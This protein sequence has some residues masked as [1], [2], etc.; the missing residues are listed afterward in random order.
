MYLF[1]IHDISQETLTRFMI[2]LLDNNIVNFKMLVNEETNYSN[3][4]D[5]IFFSNYTGIKI[6]YEYLY[7]NYDVI[8]KESSKIIY[9]NLDS[10]V[11]QSSIDFIDQIKSIYVTHDSISFINITFDVKYCIYDESNE[12]LE[13][14]RIDMYNSANFTKEEVIEELN[15]IIEGHLQIKKVYQKI[16]KKEIDTNR[17][18]YSES[19][20]LFN[21][22]SANMDKFFLKTLL[23]NCENSNIEYMT[24]LTEAF[25][26]GTLSKVEPFQFELQ[27]DKN[28][29][30]EHKTKSYN[31]LNNIQNI[32]TQSKDKVTDN[33]TINNKETVVVQINTLIEKTDT[34]IENKFEPVY[35][36]N[37]NCVNC[38][39]MNFSEKPNLFT[40]FCSFKCRDIIMNKKGKQLNN[41]R[42]SNTK[43]PRHA[44]PRLKPK[45][46]WTTLPKF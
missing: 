40:H 9:L 7:N 39:K 14:Q 5:Y 4:K 1:N 36:T 15:G 11:F 12:Y 44:K 19:G 22:H 3:Y 13:K 16:L 38:K 46:N 34:T 24:V 6:F 35:I 17:F 31:I 21:T 25:F 29:F 20:F 45:M 2:K 32:H 33:E 27:L 30:L 37:L 42:I 10:S 23:E 8:L 18:Y 41:H 26:F 28:Y 43:L